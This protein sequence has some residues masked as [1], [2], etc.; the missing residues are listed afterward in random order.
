MAKIS[1]KINEAN[2]AWHFTTWLFLVGMVVL[3]AISLVKT[4]P[5]VSIPSESGVTSRRSTSVTSPANT[6]PY[7][8]QQL[9]LV[10]ITFDLDVMLVTHSQESNSSC[11]TFTGL[12]A[13]QTPWRIFRHRSSICYK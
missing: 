5:S 11:P 4:P 12:R 13:R 10:A 6:P 1:K 3:R 2:K 9:F 7:H 8:P